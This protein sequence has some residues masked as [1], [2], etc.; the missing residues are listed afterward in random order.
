MK[1]TIDR[2]GRVVVPRPIRQKLG[3][4]GGEELEVE[5][6]DGLIEMRPATTD[7]RIVETAE[8]PVAQPL[9]ELPPMT[10]E[11]VREVLE[12]VRR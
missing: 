11:M 4:L 3:L 10:D 5:E 6:R 12:K 8:G 2:S 1:T 9:T 7:V